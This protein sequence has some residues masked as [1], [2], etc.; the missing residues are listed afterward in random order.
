M[1]PFFLVLGI[2]LLLLSIVD[3]LWTT[4]WVDGSGGPLSSRL[5]TWTW[6]ALRRLGTRDSRT[7]SLAGPIILTLTLLTWVGLLWVGWMFVFAG[8][9]D[10]LIDTQSQ[11]PVTWV[12]RMYFVA[13]AMFTMGNGEYSPQPGIWRVAASLTTASGMLFI[14]LAVSYV[15]SILGA[16][17]EK[18]SFA[19]A[20]TGLGTG[21][22]D[23][24]R[25]GWNGKDLRTLDLPLSALATQLTTLTV[26]HKAYPILHYYHSERATDAAAMAVAILDEALTLL[27]FGVPED[28]RPN[29][30]IMESARATIDSHLTAL[31]NAFIEPAA[32]APPPPTLAPLS[33]MGLPTVSEDEFEQSIAGLEERRRRLRGLVQADAWYW[34]PIKESSNGS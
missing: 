32:E 33:D 4:M 1:T 34:P 19:G 12:G 14:T 31:H 18:R 29:T 27:R 23:L 25:G 2:L 28:L 6:R 15:L 13:N 21:P 16:V 20:V 11:Q 8:H 26:Q 3:L 30:A 22:V 24:I 9:L 17:N 7:L 10:A 5:G